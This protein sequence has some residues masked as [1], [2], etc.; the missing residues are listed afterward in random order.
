MRWI[1]WGLG[2]LIA[3]LILAAEIGEGHGIHI[4]LLLVSGA[5]LA[6]VAWCYQ[7]RPQ[8]SLLFAAI[9]VSSFAVIVGMHCLGKYKDWDSRWAGWL[10]FVLLGLIFIF[11]GRRLFHGTR[12]P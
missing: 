1:R 10:S 4:A 2:I 8:L 3:A 6:G 5:A 12:R 9:G 7:D 11:L